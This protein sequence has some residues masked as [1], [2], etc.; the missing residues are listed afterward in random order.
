MLIHVSTSMIHYLISWGEARLQP[1][2]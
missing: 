2:W 1:C